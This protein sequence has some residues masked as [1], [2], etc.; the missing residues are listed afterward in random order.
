M[1][2][3]NKTKLFNWVK[4]FFVFFLIGFLMFN[5][6]I[7]K[8]TKKIIK[9]HP[10][11]NHLGQNQAQA[12]VVD[13]CSANTCTTNTCAVDTCS[14]NTCG[15]ETCTV[16]M[17]ITATCIAGACYTAWVVDVCTGGNTCA[18]YYPG[19]GYFD[20]CATAGCANQIFVDECSVNTCQA[21]SCS[22]YSCYVNTCSTPT[23]STP[24]C[25]TPTCAVGTCS[26]HTPE[27]DNIIGS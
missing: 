20:T 17:C 13:T 27:I 14:A 21:D 19:Y 12:A 9:N 7:G 23:C 10:F 3:G 25:S 4:K 5:S 16:A 8:F 22:A 18:A 11:L 24:T 2:L 1:T 15:T 6:G 26:T